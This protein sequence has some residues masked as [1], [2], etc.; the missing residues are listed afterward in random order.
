MK[1]VI[2][3][4]ECGSPTIVDVQVDGDI[5]TNQDYLSAIRDVNPL[6][7]Y[8]FEADGEGTFETPEVD[9]F[10][11]FSDKGQVE[12]GRGQDCEVFIDRCNTNCTSEDYPPRNGE[13]YYFHPKRT[14]DV[15]LVYPMKG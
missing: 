14:A 13:V 11:T 15:Y 12:M 2:T 9:S 4:Q 10:N 3:H 5:P 1:F 7:H 8:M 6:C